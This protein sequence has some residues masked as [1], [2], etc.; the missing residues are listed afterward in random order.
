MVYVQTSPAVIM[1]GLEAR[2]ASNSCIKLKLN[3]KSYIV[4]S[5]IEAWKAFIEESRWAHTPDVWPFPGL[6]SL[7][8]EWS[9]Q[10]IVSYEFPISEMCPLFLHQEDSLLLLVTNWVSL[11]DDDLLKAWDFWLQ[12]EHSFLL[13]SSSLQA[14]FDWISR[15]FGVSK[16]LCLDLPKVV[17]RVC[18]WSLSGKQ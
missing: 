5:I 13:T 8:G 10:P 6:V 18:F 17:F 15:A 3:L 14:V 7:S 16:I 9:Q 1:A 12:H 2:E 11:Q 4:H